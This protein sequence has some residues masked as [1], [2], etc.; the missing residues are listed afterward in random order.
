[1]AS[2]SVATPAIGAAEAKRRTTGTGRGDVDGAG[3]AST[4]KRAGPRRA[5]HI[6]Q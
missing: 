2:T 4:A 6:R 5:P 3:G 1:M